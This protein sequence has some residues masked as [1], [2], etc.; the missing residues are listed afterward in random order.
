MKNDFEL[1]N[2]RFRFVVCISFLYEILIVLNAFAIM[3]ILGFELYG[4]LG[5]I[6]SFVHL[7]AHFADFGLSNSISPFLHEFLKNKNSWRSLFFYRTVMPHLLIIFLVA[8]LSLFILCSMN[9]KIDRSVFVIVFVLIIFESILSFM[10]Q[11]LYAL[12]D[13][14]VIVALIEFGLLCL[15]FALIWG[16][17]FLYESFFSLNLILLLHLL[18]SCVCLFIFSILIYNNYLQLSDDFYVLQD[19]LLFRIFVTRANSYFLRISRNIFSI[20]FLTPLFAVKFGLKIAGFF[21]F[22][23]KL[24]KIVQSVVKLSIGYSGNGLLASVKQ[25]SFIIKQQAFSFLFD[26]LIS[27]IFTFFFAFIFFSVILIHY[28]LLRDVSLQII[29]LS[30]LF[31]FV[32]CFEF[33]FTLYEQWYINEEVSYLLIPMR[34]FELLILFCIFCLGNFLPEQILLLLLITRSI[35]LGIVIIK[36]QIKWG[37]N[38]VYEISL[39]F[40]CGLITMLIGFFYLII[41][42]IKFS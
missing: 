1:F 4:L 5:S 30:M 16:M 15:R 25:E 36:S 7:S 37:I 35:H 2:S 6:L 40:C 22:A 10:R 33:F 29:V 32:T 3:P 38:L 23:S 24:A 34:L 21:F 39:R 26:K 20:H 9:F 17:F 31:L 27:L 18:S 14:S 12:L 8:I 13:Y 41:N 19:G 11:F 42:G 28:E